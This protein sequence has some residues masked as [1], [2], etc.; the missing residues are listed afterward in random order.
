[1]KASIVSPRRIVL[2]ASSLLTATT[3]VLALLWL[4]SS[5]A[6]PAL[7]QGDVRYVAPGGADGGDCTNADNEIS[8]KKCRI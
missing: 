2:A 8:Y 7:A 4:L 6:V 3:L 5:G 1:M